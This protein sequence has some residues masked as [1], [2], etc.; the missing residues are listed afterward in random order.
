MKKL[1]ICGLQGQ[2]KGLL[3][4]LLDGHPDIFSPG[5][6]CCPGISL[7]NFDFI[8]RSLPR[9]NEMRT[10]K[11]NIFYQCFTRGDLSISVNGKIWTVSVGDIWKQLLN[12]EFYNL[13]IDVSFADWSSL[14]IDESNGNGQV[15]DFS[16]VEFLNDTIQEIVRKK[17]FESVEQLQDTIYKCFVK[18]Y[19]ASPHEYSDES[20]FLQISLANGYPAIKAISKNNVNKKILIIDRDPV[21]SA[22]TNAERLVER[23]PKIRGKNKRALE[24][25]VFSVYERTLYS[26]GYIDKF[27]NFQTK[28]GALRQKEKDIY[29]VDFDEMILNTKEAMSK[30]AAFLGIKANPIMY[31]ATL[32][33]VPISNPYGNFDLG[34][35]MHDPYKIL[36]KEQIQMLNYLF[37]GWDSKLSIFQNTYL[38]LNSL[39]L[40]FVCNGSVRKSAKMIGKLLTMFEMR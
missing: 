33:G 1:Y 23:N 7:L 17:C 26:K 8:D 19:K 35:I 6:I 4:Q 10:G 40:D 29:M 18:H 30:I 37:H 20:Y 34:K 36:S 39:R 14:I 2:G 9:M 11:Q 25:I 28:L 16:F 31:K 21:S 12:H 22:F 24:R 3:R 38:A 13:L 32:N 15:K 27:N 5:F